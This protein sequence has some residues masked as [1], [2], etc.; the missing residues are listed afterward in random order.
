[1]ALY[2][3]HPGTRCVVCQRILSTDEKERFTSYCSDDVPGLSI[4][5]EEPLEEVRRSG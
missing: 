2:L 4:R 5:F 1:M 3:L